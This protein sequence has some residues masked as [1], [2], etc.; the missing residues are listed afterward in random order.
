MAFE[1]SKELETGNP[2]IDSEHKQLIKAFNDLFVAC[3]QGRGRQELAGVVEFLQQYTKTH[4]SHEE[5]LQIANTYPLYEEHKAWHENYIKQVD[6]VA[7]KLKLEG[8]TI[9]IMG[10]VNSKAAMLMSHIK[11]VD[12]KLAKFIKEHNQL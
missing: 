5:K 6:E 7:S 12:K 9:A 10:E 4:F 1:W 2:Q 11:I 8:P 3:S